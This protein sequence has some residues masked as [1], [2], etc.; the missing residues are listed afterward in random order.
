LRSQVP[1][2]ARSWLLYD[3]SLTGRLR[4]T[5]RNGFNVRVLRESWQRPRPG[6]A[7]VLKM[8]PG[9][10]GWVREVQLLCDGKPLVFARTVVPVQTL[11][12]ARRRLVRL[13]SRPLG[14]YLFADP[15]TR[16][17][18]VELARIRDGEAMYTEATDG[19]KRRPA[20]IWGRRSVFQL[21]G[22]PLLV[23]EV[24]LP[25]IVPAP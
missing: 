18:A 20:F 19:L 2:A 25:A 22:K 16:R 12:G 1:A 5:C 23:T 15:G 3:G 9:T 21:E 7:R 10:L 4:A 13:G 17:T 24:F 8:R 14:A 6:E 11:S